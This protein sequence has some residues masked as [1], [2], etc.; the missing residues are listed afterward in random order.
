MNT[1]PSIC[2]PRA[3]II[4]PYEVKTILE[5]LFG[6]ATIEITPSTAITTN[7]SINENPFCLINCT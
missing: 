3:N 1:N 5:K 2:I 4:E 6:T 7:N